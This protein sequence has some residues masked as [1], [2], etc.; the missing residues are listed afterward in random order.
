MRAFTIELEIK[1]LKERNRSAH[2]FLTGK[3]LQ[4]PIPELRMWLGMIL[5][6]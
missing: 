5:N 2:P 1:V 3:E 6:K 4:E